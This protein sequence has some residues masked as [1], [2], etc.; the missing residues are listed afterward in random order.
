MSHR[1]VVTTGVVFLIVAAA[2]AISQVEP[3]GRRL[4]VGVLLAVPWAASGAAILR[5]PRAGTWLGLAVAAVS[6]GAA[7]W[8]VSLANVGQGRA[9]AELLF[10]SADGH[11]SWAGV[12]I[13]TLLFGI[14]SVW[15]AGSTVWLLL[16]GPVQ[17]DAA[18]TVNGG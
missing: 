1:N 11:F 9:I 18:R 15:C 13:V 7:A 2:L 3:G 8:I 12:A 10:A 16:R 14:A 4:L 5:W 6:V 17:H